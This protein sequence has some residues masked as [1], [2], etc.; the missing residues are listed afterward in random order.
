MRR[1]LRVLS[2]LMAGLFVFAAVVQYND[3]DP[4]RWLA[5]YL[6]AATASILYVLGR[7]RWYIPM[8]VGLI[9]LAWAATLASSVWGVVRPSQ[10]FE[11][12]EMAN[13]TVEEGREM[14]GLLIVALWMVVLVIA[15][16][17]RRSTSK[18]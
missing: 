9:A 16:L 1:V 5:I 11:A 6:S 17:K 2:G 4:L 13:T 10:L 8:L 14:Y 18:R 3:P 15:T 7:L 12:W